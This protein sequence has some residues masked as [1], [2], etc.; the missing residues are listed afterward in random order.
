MFK[1]YNMQLN[2]CWL[3]INK[4]LSRLVGRFTELIY[5][6]YTGTKLEGL[7]VVWPSREAETKGRSVG[8]T[9]GGKMKILNKNIWLFS[10]QRILKISPNNN[11]FNKY[12]DFLI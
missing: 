5:L 1:C 8:G 11:K 7:K 6:L 4:Q 3:N 2:G 9:V 12:I 10:A